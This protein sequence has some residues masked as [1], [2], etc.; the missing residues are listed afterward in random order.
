MSRPCVVAT[1]ASLRSSFH[2]TGMPSA[3]EIA[4]HDVLLGVDVDLGAEAA[5]DLRC[6]RPNLVLPEAVERGDERAEDVRILRRRPDGHR[7]LARFEVRDDPPRLDGRRREAVV[8]HPL[9]DDDVGVG[10]RRVDRRVVDRPVRLDAGT[11]RHQRHGEIVREVGVKDRRPAR[12]RLFEVHDGGQRIDL[13][14]D[15]VCRIA[16]D[17]PI[18]RNHHGNGLSGKPDGIDGHRPMLGRG[19]RRADRH[20]RQYF[21]DVRAGEDGFHPV[22]RRRSRR[23]DRANPSVRDVA[24]LERDVLHPDQRDVV[25]VGPASLNQPRILAAL[26]A[27]SDELWQHRS[28]RHRRHL[29]G[30]DLLDAR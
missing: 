13:D 19:E 24:A 1:N 27:L 10:E 18:P 9:R 4:E 30:V 14:H 26:H 23:I 8:H 11:R 17:V 28:I 2:L 6:D 15:R 21:G 22:H 25:D 20:R 16:R 3:F 5:S 29:P 7:A 12:H